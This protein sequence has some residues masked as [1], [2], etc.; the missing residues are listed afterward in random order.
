MFN[1]STSTGVLPI[2]WTASVCKTTSCSLAIFPI[3]STGSIVPISLLANIMEIRKVSLEIDRFNSSISTIP[4]S[5]TGRYLTLKPCFSRCLQVSRTA[6]CSM[7]EVIICGPLASLLF[8][9]RY[10]T[11]LMARLSDSVPPAVNIISF[12]SPP[13]VSA[14]FSLD[15][16]TAS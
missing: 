14:I 2:A 11:P 16:S 1:L 5:S 15:S 9:L 8:L 7:A 12:A 3:S 4:Y 10:A 13:N 6:G